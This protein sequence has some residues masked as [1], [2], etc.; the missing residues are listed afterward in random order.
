MSS[1]HENKRAFLYVF[2]AND[3]ERFAATKELVEAYLKLVYKWLV[4]S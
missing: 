1:C 3:A 4:A 2:R